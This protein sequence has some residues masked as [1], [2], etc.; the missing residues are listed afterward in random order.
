MKFESEKKKDS[1]NYPASR[2]AKEVSD[3]VE[4]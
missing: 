1:T 3:E 2:E 4:E